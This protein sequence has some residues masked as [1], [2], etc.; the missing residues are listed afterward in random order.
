MKRF[1]RVREGDTDA[2][3]M[4][5]VGERWGL[6]GRSIHF[7]D[8]LETLRRIFVEEVPGHLVYP[9]DLPVDT[10]HEGRV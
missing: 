8:E 3:K 1:R 5:L 6:Y 4:G 10:G 2:W 9:T 7:R